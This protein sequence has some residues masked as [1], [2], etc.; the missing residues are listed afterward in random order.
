MA[1]FKPFGISYRHEAYLNSEGTCDVPAECWCEGSRIF[2]CPRAV[3]LDSYPLGSGGLRFTERL[4]LVASL[5]VSEPR[6]T[7]IGQRLRVESLQDVT[8][9]LIQS[10]AGGFSAPLPQC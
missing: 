3:W 6:L 7:E 4:R 10:L 2:K 5:K 8:A 9:L 1:V